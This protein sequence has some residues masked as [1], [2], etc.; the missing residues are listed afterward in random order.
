M[1]V[2][3]TSG[4]YE[5]SQ[6]AADIIGAALRI[7][8]TINEDETPTGAQMINSLAAMNAMVKG[9]GVSGIHLWA[10]E[11]AILFPQ[12]GQTLYRLGSTS[13]DHA[14]LYNHSEMTT[15]SVDAA[16]AA[17]T[18]RLEDVTGFAVGFHIGIQIDN[19]VN[20]WTTVA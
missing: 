6:T 11:E 17:T 10:E 8:Q 1:A 15:L 20:F 2:L 5:F 14:T 13:P 19:G 7:T 4:S 18:L 9:W 3:Q 16:T 12:P